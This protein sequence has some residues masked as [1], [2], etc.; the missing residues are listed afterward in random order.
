MF[1]PLLVGA[2]VSGAATV[3]AL[4]QHYRH[5]FGP[6]SLAEARAL[7]SLPETSI[8]DAREGLVKL[9]GVLGCM[10]QKD[11]ELIRKR[12]PWVD[13]VV[14]PGQLHQV[15]TLVADV[16]AGGGPRLEVSLPVRWGLSSAPA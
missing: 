13:L 10:A 1:V 15:P 6:M 7:A 2:A 16:V 11:Q 3:G 4:V 12:A 5:E 14:G 9:V 8:L